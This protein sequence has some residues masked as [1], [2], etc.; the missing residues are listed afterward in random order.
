[1]IY[2]FMG[3]NNIVAPVS[4]TYVVE[5]CPFLLRGQGAT[6]YQLSGNVVG[7]FNNCESYCN[8]CYKMEILH[9]MVYLVN[10]SN[11]HCILDIPRNKG[12]RFRRSCTSFWL[13]RYSWI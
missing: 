13:G 12:P 6:L 3:F 10:L 4:L 2:L 9:R 8:G 5:V 11:E 7:F 1:M